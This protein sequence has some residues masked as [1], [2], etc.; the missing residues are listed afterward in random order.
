MLDFNCVVGVSMTQAHPLAC[1]SAVGARYWGGVGVGVG[2]KE[3][4]EKK[5]KLRRRKRRKNVLSRKVL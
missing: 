4:E 2:R 3:K 5:R 1:S